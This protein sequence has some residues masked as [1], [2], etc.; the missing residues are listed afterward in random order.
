EDAIN[1]GRKKVIG[2]MLLADRHDVISQLP[3]ISRQEHSGWLVV[4]D[5]L[6][7]E[8]LVDINEGGRR[9]GK[10]RYCGCLW[11]VYKQ[12]IRDADGVIWAGPLRL[13]PFSVVWRACTKEKGTASAVPSSHFVH[14][15][16]CHAPCNP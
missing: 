7:S 13:I 8:R 16:N 4:A 5:L 15:L 10:E 9:K 14:S 11:W 1:A 3:G 2:M 6:H 12:V